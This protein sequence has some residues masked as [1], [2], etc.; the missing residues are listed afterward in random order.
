[1]DKLIYVIFMLEFMNFCKF[2]NEMRAKV[3]EIYT[4][5]GSK[6]TFRKSFIFNLSHYTTRYLSRGSTVFID[7]LFISTSSTSL[8]IAWVLRSIVLPQNY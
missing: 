8:S 6:N 3:D 2:C 1:M 7:I 5:F 4:F